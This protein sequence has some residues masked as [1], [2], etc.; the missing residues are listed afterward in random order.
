MKKALALL[1]CTVLALMAFSACTDGGDSSPAGGNSS[2]SSGS[3]AGNTGNP[4][5]V[6]T[7]VMSFLSFTIPS[8]DAEKAVEDAIN[9]ITRSSIGVEIDLLIMDGPTYGQ[10]IPLMLS[11]GEQ[12]DIYSILGLSFA[13]MV[14]NGYALDLEEND[15]I[16]TYGQGIISTMGDYLDGCRF[17]GVLYGLP[18]N[19]DMAGPNG[20]AVGADYLDAIEWEYDPD[21]VNPITIEKL[22]EMFALLYEEFPDKAV[23]VPQPTARAQILCDGIGGDW[24]GVLMDPENS[25]EV[26]NMFASEEYLELCKMYY[27]WNQLGYISS[28]ALTDESAGVTMVSSGRGM[29]YACAIKPGIIV[30]ES[31]F[32]GRPIAMFQTEEKYYLTSS[33]LSQMPWCINSNTEFA[34]AAIKLMNALYTDAGLSRLLC[35]GVEGSDYVV[36][37]DG[38][39][40]YPEGVDATTVGYHPLTFILPNQFIAGV[41]EGNSPD[42]WVETEEMN[43]K[44]I[45]SL[46]LGFTFDNTSVSTEFAALSNIYDEFSKQI[47][48]GFID[49]ETGIAEMLSRMENAGM[50][51]YIAEKQLQ[52]DAWAA[53]VG[54]A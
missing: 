48:Y 32:N 38:L 7:V 28:D 45:P 35:F 37:D 14:N 10:Q 11:G 34:E 23:F 47:E 13:S 50:D 8:P 16:Q 6:E 9:E 51:K 27:K 1:L 5:E 53:G 12:L 49:P 24:F 30:Q 33:T 21:S 15:L 46:A 40:T 26:S 25:L 22:E 18:Q 41:W 29:A 39:L 3:A 42:V 2:L 4:A 17:G 36:R 20:Y 44:A 19:R 54:I 52:F 43:S 31:A